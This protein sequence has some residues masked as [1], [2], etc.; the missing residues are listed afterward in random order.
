[1]T[2]TNTMEHKNHTIDATG[3]SM[4]R[5]ATEVAT[6]LLGKDTT[7]VKKNVV[8]NVTVHVSHASGM[9]IDEKKLTQ[10]VYYS[11]SG[12]L[13]NQRKQVL[14]DVLANPKKGYSDALKRAVMGMLP[15]NTLREKRM[16]HL[17]VEE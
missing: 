4:G 1:M 3:K 2:N 12:W 5:V 8:R 11:H 7:T 6:V 9:K 14:K 13:G 10:K 17:I 15:K 16:K